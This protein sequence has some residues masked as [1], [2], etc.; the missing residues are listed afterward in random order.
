MVDAGL[1]DLAAERVTLESLAVSIAAPRLRREG[2]PIGPGLD[3]PEGRLFDLLRGCLPSRSHRSRRVLRRDLTRESL[4]ALMSELARTAPRGGS[5]RVYLVGG[6]TAV[7]AG[8]R[9]ATIDA[10]LHAD[11]DEVFRDI[12]GIKERL[13]LNLR[14]TP[15]TQ[16]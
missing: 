2:V 16:T 14:R 3:D 6:G 7:L 10:D 13:R 9:P 8:W 15:V 1:A 5:Y 12:Q 4:R 11:D